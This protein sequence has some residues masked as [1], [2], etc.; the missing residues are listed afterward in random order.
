MIELKELKTDYVPLMVEAALESV[1]EVNPW[2]PWC[3]DDFSENNARSWILDQIKSKQA[4][5]AYEFAVFDDSGFYLGGGGINN[6]NFEHNFA[7]IGY[8]IRSSKSKNGYGTAT[9]TALAKWAHENTNLNRLEVVVARDNVASN[10]VA[11]K[12][13]FL[14]ESVA[15]SRLYLHGKYHNANIYV[16]TR[17]INQTI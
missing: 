6:I 5:T 2:M 16:L 1:S 17:H 4:G 15:N 8:W 11:K 10:R 3:S 9:L 14:L 12:A 13:G 7:N